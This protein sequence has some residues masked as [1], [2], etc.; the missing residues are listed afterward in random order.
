MRGAGAAAKMRSI[1][2]QEASVSYRLVYGCAWRRPAA[3]DASVVGS[4][5][6]PQPI[7]AVLSTHGQSAVHV[8]STSRAKYSAQKFKPQKLPMHVP[9]G[10]LSEQHH[11][12]NAADLSADLQQGALSPQESRRQQRLL[13]QKR[14][15]LLKRAAA[16]V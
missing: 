15:K 13:R 2:A 6:C 16:Q 9:Q 8:K 10:A 1:Q 7:W 5:G 4:A 12:Q 11:P 3:C 14:A